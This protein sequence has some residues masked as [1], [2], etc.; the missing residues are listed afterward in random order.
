MET[1]SELRLPAIE[2]RQSP[3]RVLYTFAVEGKLISRFATISRIRRQNGVVHGYQRPEVLAHI[4]EIRRYLE[5][6]SPMIPNAVVIAFDSRVRFETDS[7]RVQDLN[8]ARSGTVIIPMDPDVLEDEKPGFIVD[9]QQRLAAIREATLESFP[10]C[11]TAFITDDVSEQTEQFILVNS[12]KP[13]PKGLIYELLPTTHGILP[14]LLERRRLPA[15][16]LERLNGDEGSPLYTKIQTPTTPEGVIKDNSV[17]RM[18]EY[19]LND[20]VLFRL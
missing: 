2:V 9:G 3:G 4:A 13:L 15:H 12:T 14:T 10:T 8:Y 7:Q 6:S 11:V 17:L 5:G 1:K 19:S 16:L 18:L 20:G